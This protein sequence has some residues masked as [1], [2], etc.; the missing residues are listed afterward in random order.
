MLRRLTADKKKAAVLILCGLALVLLALSELAPTGDK[1][2]RTQE[3]AVSDEAYAQALETRLTHLLE[4]VDGAGRTQVLITLR[5]GAETV[6]ARDDRLDAAPE[7]TQSEQSYVTLR[8]GSRDTGL[9]LKTVSPQILGVAVVCDGANDPAVRQAVTQTVTAALGV[10]A[11]RVSVVKM[12]AE[13][14]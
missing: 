8:D 14:N 11:S 6:F 1:T 9:A 7:H 12:Q 4:A 13:R 10:G 5:S 3:T 2:A